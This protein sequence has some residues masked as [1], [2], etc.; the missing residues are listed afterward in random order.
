MNSG[1]AASL[2]VVECPL[3]RCLRVLERSRKGI[4]GCKPI[5][6]GEDGAAAR[7]RKSPAQRIMRVE[8]A[9]DEAAAMKEDQCR[10]RLRLGPVDP[11]LGIARHSRDGADLG[12]R[13]AK[14]HQAR[15][16]GAP[17]CDRE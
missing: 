15:E 4:F 16:S 1:N 2:R 8:A 17:L 6:H 9:R 13:P 10:G 3:Q 12:S 5:V 11:N 14:A 7:G